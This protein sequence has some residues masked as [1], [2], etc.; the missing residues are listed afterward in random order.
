MRISRLIAAASLG[1]PV[2]AWAQGIPIGNAV[3]GGVGIST[4]GFLQYR[5]VTAAPAPAA[6]SRKPDL[7]YVSLPGALAQWRA[8]QDA[9]QEAPADVRYLKGL[10]QIQDIFIYPADHDIVL[11]GPAEPFKA[12]NPLEPLGTITHRP[13]VQLEDLIVA[14]RAVQ[15]AARRGPGGDLYGC[16]LEN[17]ANFQEVWKPTLDR[18]GTGPRA[19]LQ[20]EMKKALGPQQVKLYGV[21]GDTRV[22]LTMLAADYRLKR[23]SMGLETIAGLGNAL[24]A[25]IAAPRIWFEAAYDPLLVSADGSAFEL[26]GPRLKVLAG[27]QQFNPEGSNE[28][29]KRFG[30]NFS[31]KM[32]DV[33]AKVEAIADLQNV[34]DCFLTAALVRQDRLLAK[35]GLDFAWLLGAQ[36]AAQ[37][38]T[39]ALPVPRTAETLVHIS[40]NVLAQGGVSLAYASLTG[41]PRNTDATAAFA[42]PPAR[43]NEGWFF[44]KPR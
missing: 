20:A 1:L 38:K 34:T 32:T 31:K 37:Y 23:L 9:G 36:G 26:R 22:A 18:F 44:V 4:D 17:P 7:L 35:A 12:D 24:G 2:L 30:E 29:Q 16:S 10:T 43:P 19:T 25:E 6:A 11:A 5:Q 8:A 41:V 42:T 27:P 28:A 13:I 15:P 14:L 21:P 39:A 3:V 40:G 33:A